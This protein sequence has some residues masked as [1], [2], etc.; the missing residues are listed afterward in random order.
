MDQQTLSGITD[1][2]FSLF[3][4]VSKYCVRCDDAPPGGV[5]CDSHLYFSIQVPNK[6]EFV[7]GSPDFEANETYVH[8]FGKFMDNCYVDYAFWCGILGL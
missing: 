4:Y 6:L 1:I 3:F 2:G 7:F 5:L 8:D